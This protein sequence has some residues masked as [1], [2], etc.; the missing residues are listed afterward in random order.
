MCYVVIYFPITWQ[1]VNNRLIFNE[2]KSQNIRAPGVEDQGP[3][4]EPELRTGVEQ[5]YQGPARGAADREAQD[6][7]V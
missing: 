5:E 2:S 4:Q 1:N 3:G 7:A 6:A